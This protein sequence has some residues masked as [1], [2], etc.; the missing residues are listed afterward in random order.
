[1][2]NKIYYVAQQYSQTPGARYRTDGI[3]SGQEFYEE[4]LK[5]LF[6][7]AIGTKTKLII[8]LDGTDGYATSFL[9]EAFGRLAQDFG[10]KSVFDNIEIISEEEPDLLD[11]INEYIK[12]AHK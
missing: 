9:D 3:F 10:V 11:E 6:E 4:H 8:N 12:N 1:M 7:N 2:E 5:E